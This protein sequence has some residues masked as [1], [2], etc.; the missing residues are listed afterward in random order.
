MRVRTEKT[1]RTKDALRHLKRIITD[2]RGYIDPGTGSMLFTILIGLITAGVYALRNAFVKI[3]FFLT[4]G[5][6]AKTDT[7]GA[8]IIMFSDDKRYWNVFEPI[9]EELDKRGVRAS[10]MT[11]SPDDPALN[12]SF[13]HVSCVFIG[14]GNAAFAKLNMAKADIVLSSTPGLDV[15]QWKHSRDVKWYAHIPHALTDMTMYRMFGIDYYDAML[16]NGQY[17]I[18]QVRKLEG[19]RGLPAK[20]LVLV[21]SVTMDLLDAKLA[22][23]QRH[24]AEGNPTVLL[25]PSWGKS[26]IF[27]VYGDRIIKALLSTGYH[28][29]VRPHPQSFIAEKDILDDLVAR[30]PASEQIEWNRDVDNFEVLNRSDIMVSDFSGVILDFALGF[31]RPVIYTEPNV[32]L[33]PYDACWLDETPWVLTTLPRV[34]MKL[35]DNNL[36]GIKALI[37]QCLADPRFQEG[38]DE[39]RREGWC[40]R[41]ECATRTADYLVA[42]CLELQEPERGETEADSWDAGV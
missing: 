38:R 40:H 41:G 22:N 26:S 30:F 39:V 35:D 23:A 14:K 16:L 12:R 33:A 1:P 24:S 28:I 9:C 31:D 2:E 32:D 7:A 36:D 4:G 19:A 37:D 5:R 18:N 6:T 25:A 3:R 13:E 29:I 27:S 8:P 17:Q 42:K 34:G 20:E 10:Y 21:G 15:Y 11:A